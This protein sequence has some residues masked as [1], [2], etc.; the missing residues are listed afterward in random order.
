MSILKERVALPVSFPITCCPRAR[1][2]TV[3]GTEKRKRTGWRDWERRRRG[4]EN[5]KE[6]RERGRRRSEE[7]GE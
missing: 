7:E 1:G 4:G 2:T 5:E 6:R 3:G